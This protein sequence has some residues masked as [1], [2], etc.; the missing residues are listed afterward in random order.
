MLSGLRQA[1]ADGER[2]T[3]ER[4]YAQILA[5]ESEEAVV[6]GK[7]WLAHH[8]MG[9]RAKADALLKPLDT[10]ARLYALSSFLIYPY[11]DPTPFPHLMA[12]LQR[13]GITRPP[14]M[15]IPFA[16]KIEKIQ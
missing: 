16:C 8:L 12:A 13:Q 11:F 2:D 14:P 4:L 7:K 10:P 5:D 6:D 1:C 9:K 3:A 15:A